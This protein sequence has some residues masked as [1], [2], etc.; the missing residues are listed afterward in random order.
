MNLKSKILMD[1]SRFVLL[2]TDTNH[3]VTRNLQNFVLYC[4]V[5]SAVSLNLVMMLW[6]LPPTNRVHAFMLNED[7]IQVLQDMND[8]QPTFRCVL[9]GLSSSHDA[10][11]ISRLVIRNRLS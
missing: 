3:G 5:W 4:P 8:N 6:T 1:P 11:M 2:N 9:M 7:N 10:K